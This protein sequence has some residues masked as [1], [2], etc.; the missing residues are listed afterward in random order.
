MIVALITTYFAFYGAFYTNQPI[1]AGMIVSVFIVIGGGLSILVLF[2]GVVYVASP[3]DRQSTIQ[4]HRTN[5]RIEWKTVLLSVYLTVFLFI[6]LFLTGE[7]FLGNTFLEDFALKT[8]IRR[9]VVLAFLDGVPT[10]ILLGLLISVLDKKAANFTVEGVFRYAL[11]YVL[12]STGLIVLLQINE[13]R[14]EP[15]EIFIGIGMFLMIK[16][17]VWLLDRFSEKR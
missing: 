1:D 5:Q 16:A 4:I 6:A 13:T 14:A 9:L 10:G 2:F 15:F 7:A 12:C 3:L 11:L 17:I 8:D